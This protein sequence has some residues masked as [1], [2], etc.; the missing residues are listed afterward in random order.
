MA[1]T[2]SEPSSESSDSENDEHSLPLLNQTPLYDLLTR[3]II[4]LAISRLIPFEWDNFLLNLVVEDIDPLNLVRFLIHEYVDNL[5]I[6]DRRFGLV[7]SLSRND[8]DAP[9]FSSEAWILEHLD[10]LNTWNG[11]NTY[12]PSED[13]NPE[14]FDQLQS[15]M[16]RVEPDYPTKIQRNTARPKDKSRVLPSPLVIPCSINGCIVCALVDTGSLGDFMST[17]TAD[18]LVLKKELI[19]RPLPVQLVASGSRSVINYITRVR[20]QYQKIDEDCYFD[21]MNIDGY[22]IILG[23]PFLYQY[24]V[25]VAFNPLQ[26]EIGHE[27]SLPLKSSPGLRINSIAVDEEKLKMDSARR[28]LEKYAEPICKM[29][30]ETPLPP[31]RRINHTIPIVD[32]SKQYSW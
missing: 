24:S 1:T 9:D 29:V 14:L 21:I 8:F 19:E 32:S 5:V 4:M 22:D 31:L 17:T 13:E 20:F 3:D 10:P 7:A 6:G 26:I 28:E 23:T 12:L 2:I 18:Q 11:A 25:V 30:D 15:F 16:V 27:K